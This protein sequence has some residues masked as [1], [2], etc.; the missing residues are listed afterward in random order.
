MSV[1][2]EL[3]MRC[4]SGRRMFNG[5]KTTH[6][7]L[8]YCCKF[9]TSA[10]PFSYN[11]L[12]LNHHAMF[13]FTLSQLPG[14]SH[15]LVSSY[16]SSSCFFYQITLHNWTTACLKFGNSWVPASSKLK[17]SQMH[18]LNWKSVVLWSFLFFWQINIK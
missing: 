16:V 12:I 15:T 2:Q 8:V 9:I 13:M 11:I 3:S 1:V 10:R 4:T 7:I 17:I 18:L 14:C 6:R 5:L